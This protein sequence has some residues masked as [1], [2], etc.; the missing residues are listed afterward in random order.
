MY[1]YHDNFFIIVIF[2]NSLAGAFWLGQ[3]F[4]VPHHNVT[5]ERVRSFGKVYDL[6][7]ESVKFRLLG[8]QFKVS[9]ALTNLSRE[10]P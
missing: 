9:A 3:S 6:Y 2:I 4:L 10:F 5:V 7:L 8:T 1:T